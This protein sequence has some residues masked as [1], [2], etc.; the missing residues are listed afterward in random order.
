MTQYM[1]QTDRLQP[2]YVKVEWLK[3]AYYSNNLDMV[4]YLICNIY[5]YK[6]DI[7]HIFSMSCMDGKYNFVKYLVTLYRTHTKYDKMNLSHNSHAPFRVA[8]GGSHLN[9]VKYLTMLYKENPDYSMID[10]HAFQEDAFIRACRRGDLKIVKYLISLHKYG[11]NKINIY[12]KQCDGNCL[13]FT[14]DSKM[15]K[16]LANIGITHMFLF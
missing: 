15:L 6:S 4:D 9:I 10:I 3:Q 14:H 7:Y 8:A 11:Y 1:S 12:M 16:Y 13:R 5:F 2:Y